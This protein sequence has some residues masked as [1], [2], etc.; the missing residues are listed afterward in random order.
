MIIHS[1]VWAEQKVISMPLGYAI[2][3]NNMRNDNLNI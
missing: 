1:M 3:R 2:S